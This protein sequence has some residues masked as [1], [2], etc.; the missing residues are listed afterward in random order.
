MKGSAVKIV[1]FD[2]VSIT[3]SPILNQIKGAQKMGLSWKSVT[4]TKQKGKTLK[5]LSLFP[6]I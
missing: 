6:F 5:L 1:A 2:P 4:D 3:C